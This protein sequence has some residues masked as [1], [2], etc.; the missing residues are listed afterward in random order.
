MK[1]T[2][3]YNGRVQDFDVSCL[4]SFFFSFMVMRRGGQWAEKLGT[5]RRLFAAILYLPVVV[6]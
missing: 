5:L 2:G 3:Q 1:G 4:F 6:Q